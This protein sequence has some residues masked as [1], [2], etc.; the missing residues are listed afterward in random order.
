LSLAAVRWVVLVNVERLVLVV[1]VIF[2]FVVF[3]TI[4]QL[5]S[6]EFV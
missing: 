3:V 6:P 5:S 2:C 1:A 4:S